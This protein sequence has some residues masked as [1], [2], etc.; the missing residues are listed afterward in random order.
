MDAWAKD[1]GGKNSGLLR[2]LGDAKAE[3]TSAL[4]VTWPSSSNPFGTDRSQRYMAIVDNNT[5]KS[6]KVEKDPGTFEVSL[7]AN[8]IEELKQ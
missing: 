3:L 6:I 8:A 7:A 1:S 2:F 5:V 4:G